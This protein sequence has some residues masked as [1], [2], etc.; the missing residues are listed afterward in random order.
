[1]Y[2]KNI[3]KLILAAQLKRSG[4]DRDEPFINYLR[5]TALGHEYL[6]KYKPDAMYSEILLDMGICYESLQDLGYWTLNEDYYKQCIREQ[7]HSDV[8]LRCYNRLE[9]SIYLGYTGSSGTRLP[10]DVRGELKEFRELAALTQG[11]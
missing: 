1:M 10:P 11:H 2:R 4:S 6:T 8:A 3:E 7:P 9:Q 5:A